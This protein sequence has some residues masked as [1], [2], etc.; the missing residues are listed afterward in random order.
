M[1]ISPPLS[2]FLRNK[3]S[4]PFFLPLMKS[5]WL[6]PNWQPLRS[7]VGHQTRRNMSVFQSFM[8]NLKKGLDKKPSPSKKDASFVEKNATFKNSEANQQQNNNSQNPQGK[9]IQQHYETFQNQMRKVISTVEDSPLVKSGKR[10]VD[11]VSKETSKAA[12]EARKASEKAADKSMEIP[13]VRKVAKGLHVAKEELF[14][15]FAKSSA[16]YQRNFQPK[17]PSELNLQSGKDQTFS[18]SQT[19]SQK[20][21]EPNLEA[22]GVVL[23]KDSKWFHQWNEFK[24]NNKVV[25]SLFDLKTKYDESDNILVRSLRLFTDKISDTFGG[26]FSENE[27]AQVF[28]EIMKI[29]PKFNREKFIQ[30]CQHEIIPSILEAYHRGNLEIL[31]DWCTPPAF[32]LL[33]YHIEMTKNQGFQRD[34]KILDIR[35]VDIPVAKLMDQGP[36]LIL[37]FFV[38][39]ILVLRNKVGEVVEGDADKIENCFYVL[40]LCR[41]QTIFDSFSAWRVME[42]GIQASN[43]TW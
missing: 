8:S 26:A 37:T 41:D 14:E 25:Q 15:D 28:A 7:T 24:D 1:K 30:T 38:Q 20:P 4:P 21:I 9:T 36:V 3:T 2:I 40:A 35:N 13:V 34:C 32:S 31:K 42:F 39:Q 10:V 17:K 27:T 6:S 22:Q 11:A 29:D 43:E 12:E 16:P 5:S 23:H 19:A 18:P 33:S